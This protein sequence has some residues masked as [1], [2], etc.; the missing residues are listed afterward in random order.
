MHY[1]GKKFKTIY[2]KKLKFSREIYI[3][4]YVHQMCPRTMNIGNKIELILRDF[5]VRHN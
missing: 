3:Y 4:I 5:S 2:R 1:L